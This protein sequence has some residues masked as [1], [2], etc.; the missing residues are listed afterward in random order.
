MLLLG[1][2]YSLKEALQEMSSVGSLHWIPLLTWLCGVI[3]DI[4][5]CCLRWKIISK[6]GSSCWH[7]RVCLWK[8]GLWISLSSEEQKINDLAFTL[9]SHP[10]YQNNKLALVV[11]TIDTI[12]AEFNFFIV[13][14]DDILGELYLCGIFL[15]ALDLRC[16][17]WHDSL[18]SKVFTR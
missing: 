15:I 8:S 11:V 4:I 16:L 7:L 17:L 14:L 1:P 18:N 9:A 2:L 5:H 10:N 6:G 12:S 3:K 13:K